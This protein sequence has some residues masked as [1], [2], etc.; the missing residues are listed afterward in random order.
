MKQALIETSNGRMVEYK[1]LK[2]VTIFTLKYRAAIPQFE[3]KVHYHVA[4]LLFPKSEPL[5][6]PNWSKIEKFV[7]YLADHAE[8]IFEIEK[9]NVQFN[10]EAMESIS[11]NSNESLEMKNPCKSRKYV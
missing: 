1:T 6:G 9:N 5:I 8:R 7:K 11:E 4:A 2:L 3:N 10:C